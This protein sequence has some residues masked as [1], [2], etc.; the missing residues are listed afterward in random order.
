M[1]FPSL[2]SLRDF[3]FTPF[4]RF[5]SIKGFRSLRR[6]TKG[7]AFGNRKPFEKGLTENFAHSCADYL[8]CDQMGRGPHGYVAMQ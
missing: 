1:V 3:K 4:G 8:F 5:G 7:S 6:A 2:K